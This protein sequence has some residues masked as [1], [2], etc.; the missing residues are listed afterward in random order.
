MGKSSRFR[1]SVFSVALIIT[2]IAVVMSIFA[3]VLIVVIAD[4]V[5]ELVIML[6][7]LL[8][9]AVVVDDNVVVEV[10]VVVLFALTETVVDGISG[11]K[12]NCGAGLGFKP[13]H[14]SHIVPPLDD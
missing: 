14:L 5:D 2:G 10:I 7:L 11:T 12:Y 9:L 1:L 13:T 8:L 6:P 3:A 4:A